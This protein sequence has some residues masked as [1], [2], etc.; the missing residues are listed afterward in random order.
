MTDWRSFPG[1]NSYRA[2]D[3]EPALTELGR[4]KDE[5][6]AQDAYNRVLLAIGNSHRGTLYPA[7]VAAAPRILEVALQSAGWARY[8]AFEVLV[9]LSAFE[10][11]GGFEEFSEL[12]GEI[13]QLKTVVV[14]TISGAREQ[15]LSVLADGSEMELVR[16]DALDVLELLDQNLDEVARVLLGMPERS[17]QGTFD[18][19]R[20]K[21]LVGHGYL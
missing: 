14:G 2:E 8:A 5:R 9:E 17:A 20:R 19:Q 4:A 16:I 7:A 18:G 10:A 6:S 21:F 1:P 3:V 15:L 11:E 12:G 13:V